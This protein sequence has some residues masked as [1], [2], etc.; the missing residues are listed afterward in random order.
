[1]TV[2][3]LVRKTALLNYEIIITHGLTDGGVGFEWQGLFIHDPFADPQY[4]AFS[5]DPVEQYGDANTGSIFVSD[6]AKAFEMAQS[7]CETSPA[8]IS[9]AT[10]RIIKGTRME[11]LPSSKPL[12]ICECRVQLTF[13]KC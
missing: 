12:A 10:A 13:W 7:N 11:R 1:M 4:G 9:G 5:V 3:E 8:K 2:D 6:P